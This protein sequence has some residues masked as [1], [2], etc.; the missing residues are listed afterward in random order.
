[1]KI[2]SKLLTKLAAVLMVTAIK[3]LMKTIRLDL[4]SPLPELICYENDGSER[5]FYSSWHDLLIFPLF[6]GKQKHMGSLVSKHQDGSFLAE[7]M[8]LLGVATVR[9]SSSR[10]GPQAARQV[11]EFVKHSH[12]SMTPDG[13]RGPRR[14]MKP[15]IVFMASHSG[16]PIVPLGAACVRSWKI[17]GNWTDLVLPKPFTKVY[18]LVGMPIDV[19][20]DLSREEIS[21]YTQIAQQAM[22]DLQA[23][24]ERLAAGLPEE[25][26]LRAAA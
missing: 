23:E 3:L 26:K 7:S 6:C 9:G 20:P 25:P 16:R 8:K 10:G 2:R 4:R 22:D 21:R 11:I 14:V 18:F 19:P 15:G 24:A 12:L 5:F 13:P 1:M 17:R